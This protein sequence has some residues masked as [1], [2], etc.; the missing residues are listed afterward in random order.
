MIDSIQFGNNSKVAQLVVEVDHV[1]CACAYFEP[2]I[3]KSITTRHD[4][5][6]RQHTNQ[7]NATPINETTIEINATHKVDHDGNTQ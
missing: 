4:G 5:D 3:L 6:K 7:R 1:E 2:S